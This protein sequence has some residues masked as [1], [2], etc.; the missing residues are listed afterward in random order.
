MLEKARFANENISDEEEE[1]DE[2]YLN[3]HKTIVTKK[4]LLKLGHKLKRRT[5]A[6][7]HNESFSDV[8]KAL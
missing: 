4:A 3:A 2:D 6:H 7:V 1:L 5:T 8:K